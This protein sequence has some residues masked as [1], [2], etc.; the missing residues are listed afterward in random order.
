MRKAL[1]VGLLVLAAA[2]RCSYAQG[3]LDEAF[4][5]AQSIDL[6]T[7]K[8]PAVVKL[9]ETVKLPPPETPVLVKTFERSSL[10]EVLKPLFARPGTSG[11]T[12]NGR[13]IAI[14]KTQFPKEYHDVLQHELVH[15][16][17]TMVAAPRQLP[18]WFQEGSAVHFST[19]KDRKFYGQPSKVVRG[20]VEGRVVDL[21]PAYK[22][23]LQSF[24]F[25]IERVGTK[26]FNTWFR[27]A[28]LTG[29]VDARSLLGLQNQSPS[30]GDPTKKPFPLWLGLVIGVVVVIVAVVGYVGSRRGGDYY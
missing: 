11:V 25:L 16:Y 2:A 19:D 20:A 30:E 8:E 27:N 9:R 1:L 10:P 15:A 21:A 7:S 28:V 23:K 6:A 5:G 24:H 17:I 22:Q 29:R 14:I 13:Y 3:T 18:F 12:A 26:R 4:R